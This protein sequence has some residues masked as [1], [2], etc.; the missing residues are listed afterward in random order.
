MR[1]ELYR[2]TELTQNQI[3]ALRTLSQAVYPPES[4]VNWPG[5]SIEWAAAEWR[6]F[7]WDE[8]G[9]ALS[10][11]GVF[12]RQGQING[13]PV[14]IGGVGGILTHPDSRRQ[15]LASKGIHRAIDFFRDGGADFAL[16]VCEPDLVPLYKKLDWQTFSGTLLVLQ[17]GVPCEFTFNLPMTLGVL[18]Q[19]PHEG[20][21][22]LMGPPW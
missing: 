15:G 12:L 22:D 11:V 21:I 5:R 7:C 13:T 17:Q 20:I 18:S 8:Q 2:A 4:I 3:A 9:K 1:I 6:I 14:T 16:L 19:S 10:H